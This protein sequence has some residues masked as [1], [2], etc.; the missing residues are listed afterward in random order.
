MKKIHL[1]LLGL[2]FCAVSCAEGDRSVK[3]AGHRFVDLALPS[4]TL[5]AA[6][7]IGAKVDADAGDYF[8]W[9]ETAPK[10]DYSWQTYALGSGEDTLAKYNAPDSCERLFADDDAAATLWGE[11]CR[12]PTHAQFAEL[13]DTLNCTWRW[14]SRTDSNGDDVCGFLVTSVRNG[15]SIFLPAAGCRDG[16]GYFNR[17]KMGYYWSGVRNPLYAGQAFFLA[18]EGCFPYTSFDSRFYGLTVRAVL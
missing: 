12:M 7:N 13:R 2:I 8:A 10:S 15:N 16:V 5:W 17:G 3:I 6:T 11:G 9:G 18:L 14:T 1:M 4:G